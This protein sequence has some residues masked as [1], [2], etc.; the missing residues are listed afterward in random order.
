MRCSSVMIG[1]ADN[2]L[3]L[4]WMVMAAEASPQVCFSISPPT[5]LSS[6]CR[7]TFRCRADGLNMSGRSCR[8]CDLDDAFLA[9]E[10]RLFRLQARSRICSCCGVIA[11]MQLPLPPLCMHHH[12]KRPMSRLL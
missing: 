2:S 11:T 5:R 9:W 12:P 6:Q 10:L 8:H 1:S 4:C 7:V 3:V